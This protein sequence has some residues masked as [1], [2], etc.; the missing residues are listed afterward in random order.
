VHLIGINQNNAVLRS[1][2]GATRPVETLGT[3]FN[4]S[5]TNSF[6]DMTGKILIDKGRPQVL[7]PPDIA[8]I[9]IVRIFFEHGMS[10]KS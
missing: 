4:D 5:N 6:M 1:N 2:V 9:V 7:K 8:C 3:I 10:V